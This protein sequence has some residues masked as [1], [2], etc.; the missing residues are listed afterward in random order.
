MSFWTSAA[1]RYSRVL[2]S[3]FRRR[4]GGMTFPFT[5]LGDALRRRRNVMILL[6]DMHS[7]FPVKL[8]NG[9][10]YW[11]RNRAV[12][13]VMGESGNVRTVRPRSRQRRTFTCKRIEIR[14]LTTTT[15]GPSRIGPKAVPMHLMLTTRRPP[16]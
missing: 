10:S 12:H 5:R 6:T 2:V 8:N 14:R 7:Y 15:Y 1:V 16:L 13:E 4:I 11:S 3:A 9:E